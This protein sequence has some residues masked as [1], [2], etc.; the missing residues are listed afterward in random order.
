[1]VEKGE[2]V[3]ISFEGKDLVTGKVFDTTSEETAKKEGIFREGSIFKPIPVVIGKGELVQGLEEALQE[4]KIGEER[5]LDIS[6]EKGFGERNPELVRVIPLNE[7][8]KRNV[9]PA[10]GMVVDIN[11][12]YGKIQSISGGRVRVDFNPDLA[13]RAVQ[14]KLKIEKKLDSSEEKSK[15]LFEKYFPFMKQENCKLIGDCFEASLDT[16]IAPQIGQLKHVFAQTLLEFV[17]EVKK[18]KFV[19]EF[20]EDSFK[21]NKNKK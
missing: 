9:T 6:P 2:M 14:Y 15:A 16:K 19:E 5:V 12:M 20:N 7:F 11:N 1:M 8:K 3:L 4:M 17:P 13:G 18:V 21:S 10:T